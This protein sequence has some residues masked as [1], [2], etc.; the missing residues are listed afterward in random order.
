MK[1]QTEHFTLTVFLWVKSTT[2]NFETDNIT[3]SVRPQ[4]EAFHTGDIFVRKKKMQSGDVDTDRIPS[5]KL[6]TVI[7]TT[8]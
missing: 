6:Q 8:R 5:V 2:Q 7:K 1:L 3:L 4:A